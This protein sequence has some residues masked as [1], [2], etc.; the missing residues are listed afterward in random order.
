MRSPATRCLV[1]FV[2][3]AAGLFYANTPCAEPVGHPCPPE[4]AYLFVPG[5]DHVIRLP[6]G[7]YGSTCKVCPM[8]NEVVNILGLLAI[9]IPKGFFDTPENW[10]TREEFDAIR[11]ES[12]SDEA[13]HI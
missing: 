7:L 10:M 8:E 4:D 13:L 11:N 2:F 9:E 6:K 3:V 1:A 5:L 12:S